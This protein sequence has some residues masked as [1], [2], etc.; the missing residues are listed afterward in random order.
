MSPLRSIALGLVAVLLHCAPG[1]ADDISG[2]G[3]TFVSSIL[4][5]WSATYSA[6]STATLAYQPVGSGSGIA[7]L[8]SGVVDFAVSDAPLKP[9]ELQRFGLLQFP[10]VM[11]GI[12]P[13]VN[14][15]GVNLD[16]VKPAAMKFTGSL[17]A[18]IYM[19]KVTK[20][21]DPRIATLNPD[22]A[23]PASPIIVVHRV[24]S[25]GTTFNWVNYL[26]KASPEW[27]S[28]IGEGLSVAWPVGAGGK[29]NEGVAAFVRST[30][31]AIGYVDY[32]TALRSRLAYGLVENRAGKF[33]L[34][35]VATFEAAAASADWSGAGDFDVV[36]TDAP[37]DDSYPIAATSFVLM[38]KSA[39]LPARTRAALAFFRWAL[40][41]GQALAEQTGFAALPSTVVS[42]VDT[43]WKTRFASLDG[44]SAENQRH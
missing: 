25:S 40:R 35:G 34:P 39:K 20:W 13:I 19:G 22:V 3:S 14:L 28:R 1:R 31:N 16:G 4:S 36:M 8:K 30:R 12:V 24:E 43:C 33:V 41:D 2:A 27:R 6:S 29:G 44:L 23:L 15:E 18:D 11:G 7:S 10:L 9:A 38:Y 37:G 17:L 32:A 42:Q 5:R 26:A 21:N